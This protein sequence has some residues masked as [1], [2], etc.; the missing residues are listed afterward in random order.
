MPFLV[1]RNQRVVVLVVVDVLLVVVV[2]C[3]DVIFSF[4]WAQFCL[5]LCTA[6]PPLCLFLCDSLGNMKYAKSKVRVLSN[7]LSISLFICVCVCGLHFEFKFDLK[8]R[9]PLGDCLLLLWNS[10]KCAFNVCLIAEKAFK[11]RILSAH[12]VQLCVD[13]IVGRYIVGC[14]VDWLAD[15]ETDTATARDIQIQLQL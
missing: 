4:S 15:T 5:V 6:P 1:I 7:L 3:Q 9:T 14:S 8:F 13:Y 12:A 10:A 11:S 2:A